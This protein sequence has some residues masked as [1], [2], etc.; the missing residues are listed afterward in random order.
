[1]PINLP[2]APEPQQGEL[3]IPAGSPIHRIG[4]VNLLVAAQG[5]LSP[6]QIAEALRDQSDPSAAI[7][8]LNDMAQLAGTVAPH[9]VYA[10]H[11]NTVYVQITA[12][13]VED[14]VA[15]SYLPKYFRNLPNDR[16]WR[17][18]DLEPGLTL[19]G[20]HADRAGDA[21]EA[22]LAPVDADR[23]RLELARASPRPETGS[24]S[25]GFSNAGNRYTGR[26]FLDLQAGIGNRWGDQ[27]RLESRAKVDVFGFDD[28]EQR[29]GSYHEQALGW[30]RVTPW[31]VFGLE[32]RYL[33]YRQTTADT[34]LSGEI[35]SVEGSWLKILAA[36]V[37][38]R[39]VNEAKLGYL[40]DVIE[41]NDG[42][43]LRKELYPA[44]QIGQTYSRRL[45]G[46]DE[47]S[48]L[49]LDFSLRKGLGDGDSLSKTSDL[50]FWTLKPSAAVQLGLGA[51]RAGMTA[52]GQVGSDRLPDQELWVL[53][54][55]DSLRAWLPGVALG[56]SGTFTQASLQYRL[57]ELPIP[58]AVLTASVFTEYGSASQELA[59]AAPDD[60][61]SADLV[62]AGVEISLQLAKKLE[63]T[64][65][66][67]WPIH[68]RGVGQEQRDLFRAD[69]YFDLVWAF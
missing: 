18:T 34:R 25:L 68:E 4:D 22:K 26:E 2:P 17:D 60:H 35:W 21:Y 47:D 20:L 36:G 32:G 69:F 16:P 64:V 29:S 52:A 53:G 49:A 57:E 56:D 62:D 42:T 24:L 7:R 23:Y 48:K 13:R 9:T 38:W 6:T 15:T 3:V 55:S 1:M 66:R 28:Q 31:G 30:D 59:L 39:W 63:A 12:G 41:D 27:F 5:V 54:G 46:W 14:V 37:D 61:A 10:R 50:G 44:L 19:A 43:E 58:K 65:S 8:A 67:A 51:L 45:H 40:H 33:D 11:D